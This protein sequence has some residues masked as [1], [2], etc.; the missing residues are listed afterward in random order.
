MGTIRGKHPKAKKQAPKMVLFLLA[1]IACALTCIDLPGAGER[2]E[3]LVIAGDEPLG[4]QAR[5]LQQIYPEIRAHV[6]DTLGWKFRSPPRVLLV[7]DRETFEKMSGNP[8]ISAFAV[9]SQHS[10]VIHLS[11][12]ISEPYLLHETFEHEL[13]HLLLH[14]HIRDRFLP[15]WLDEGT[16]QWVSGSLGEIL[17]GKGVAAGAINPARH[18]IPLRQLAMGFPK[19]KDSLIQA[20]VES[21]LF[22]EYLVA[23]HG[24]ESLLG[25]LQQLR[26][27]LSIEQAIS[28]ATSKSLQNLE[29]EW[30]EELRS[31]EMWLVWV[32]QNLYELLFLL[33]AILTIVAFVR[34]MIRKKRYDP[35]EEDEE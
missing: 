11:P 20:Y 31:R 14:D 25:V 30:R 18:P 22:V 3:E 35:D 23:H 17:V 26:E 27:G 19:D 32:G 34:L 8:L 21:R 1:C 6:E 24:K 33:A 29:D 2:G 10:I 15:R 28:G 9:P 16:C 12:A 5:R 13:C 4:L 7:S